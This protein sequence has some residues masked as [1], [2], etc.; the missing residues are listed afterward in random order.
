[1]SRSIREVI[2]SSDSYRKIQR[3]Q[4]ERR[5][6]RKPRRKERWLA[7]IPSTLCHKVLDDINVFIVG[8]RGTSRAAHI[9]RQMSSRRVHAATLGGINVHGTDDK[10]K[11]VLF[12]R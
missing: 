2:G 9:A 7:I 4:L 3:A 10:I 11:I 12:S 5:S 6:S 1:M 8:E